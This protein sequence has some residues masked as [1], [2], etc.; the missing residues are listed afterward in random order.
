MAYTWDCPP[1]GV[2]VNA[3]ARGTV[4]EPTGAAGRHPLQTVQQAGIRADAWPRR[5]AAAAQEWW[6]RLTSGANAGAW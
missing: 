6:A 1:A 3:Q 2:D 5:A 4:R